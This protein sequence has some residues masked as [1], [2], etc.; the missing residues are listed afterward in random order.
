MI[1]RR[2]RWA[3]GLA[4]AGAAGAVVASSVDQGSWLRTTRP[5]HRP[6]QGLVGYSGDVQF[7]MDA[8]E[9]HESGISRD[10]RRDFVELLASRPVRSVDELT[11]AAQES[12][13]LLDNAA[14]TVLVTR[15]HRLPIRLGWMRDSLVVVK[16]SPEYEH[17]AGQRIVS[18]AGGA[19]DV[20]WPLFAR[21]V[22]GGTPAWLRN[23]S[24]WFF[25]VPEALRQVGMAVHNGQ[26]R[27]ELEAPDGTLSEVTL[28]SSTE[29]M[30]GGPMADFR[31][32]FPGDEGLGTRGWRTAL[33]DPD[34]GDESE[35]V[36][37]PLYLEHWDRLLLMSELPLDAGTGSGGTGS[38][39]T[40]SAGT[41]SAGTALYLRLLG[42]PDGQDPDQDLID[43]ALGRIETGDHARYIVDVRYHCG[44]D[45][46]VT[47]PLVRAIAKRA[48]AL[49]V[50][51][52]V[53][54]G[55]NTIG[56]G[57]VSAS[58]FMAHAPER[59]TVIGNDVGDR[60]RNRAQG[61]TIELP[62]SRLVVQVCHDWH[63]IS[64]EP[65]PWSDVWLPDKFL[66]QGIGDFR[67]DLNVQN[68]W[69][70]Y[71]AGRDLLVEAALA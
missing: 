14:T 39:G 34:E 53:L 18:I 33:R 30:P 25:T 1:S 4:V 67:P 70:D 13:A 64:E 46:R 57:L 65:T 27:C 26:V 45:Y 5:M 20:T 11:L 28:I 68:S 17:L 55:P 71:L 60:L 24:A 22:G 49:S 61:R 10:Q 40:G 51:I 62:H 63:D 9:R 59:T 54:V 23:R 37:S 36:P 21:F 41:G 50:P 58:Q 8:V 66:L 6:R 31:D 42:T 69:P 56:G 38:A 44:G 43:E 47:L 19:P 7:L 35:D 2:A 3:L 29:P 52:K 15:A 16:A 32:R 12:L 48:R